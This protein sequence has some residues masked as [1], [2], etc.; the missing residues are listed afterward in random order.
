[1]TTFRVVT[2]SPD[3]SQGGVYGGATMSTPDAGGTVHFVRGSDVDAWPAGGGQP[4]PGFPCRIEAGESF[5]S[6][7]ELATDSQGRAVAATTGDIIVAKSLESAS[8]PGDT[9]WC[10]LESQRE[11]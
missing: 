10:V 8:G 6:G 2:G 7:V 9:I 11:M 1:M 4:E 3:P 5:G